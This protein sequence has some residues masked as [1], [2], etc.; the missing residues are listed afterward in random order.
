MPSAS[1]HSTSNVSGH[2]PMH[3]TASLLH[4]AGCCLVDHNQYVKWDRCASWSRVERMGTHLPA[5]LSLTYL[6]H[7]GGAPA[8]T[9]HACRKLDVVDGVSGRL[10]ADAPA[11]TVDHRQG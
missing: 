11:L 10:A 3:D 1:E 5:F 8:A 7:L 9:S 4:L 2:M 6:L